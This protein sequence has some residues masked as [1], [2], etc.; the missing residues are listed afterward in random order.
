M[1]GGAG[2]QFVI[3]RKNVRL[4]RSR[5]G[6]Y[7]Q[8]RRPV[9]SYPSIDTV[10]NPRFLFDGQNLFLA[11]EVAL[12]E[13]G[14]CAILE[15]SNVLW[16]EKSPVNIDGLGQLGFPV[17]AWEFTEV[18]ESAKTKKWAYLN[19]RF[20]T[21]SFNDCT[22]LIVFTAVRIVHRTT[23]T[24]VGVGLTEILSEFCTSRTRLGR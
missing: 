21:A 23:S 16:F 11:Y 3:L 1:A 24:H 17:E 12:K 14:G 9:E 6:N 22:I 7:M 10:E 4:A 2:L 19:P 18:I 13:G 5:K 15:F 8:G 20:W